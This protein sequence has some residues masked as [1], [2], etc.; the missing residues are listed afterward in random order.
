MTTIAGTDFVFD[1]NGKPATAAPIG[2]AFGVAAGSGGNV[3]VAS[4]THNLILQIS[5]GG[6][7]RTLAGNGV[8]GFSGEGALGVTAALNFPTG[9][10]VAPDGTLYIADFE[11][12]RVRRIRA[13]GTIET[14][15]GDINAVEIGDGG[16]AL[17]A[18]L[19]VPTALAFDTQGRLYIA[20]N[21]NHRIRRVDRDGTIRTIAGTGEAGYT[22][23]GGDAV[24]ARIGSPQGIAVD[25]EG[26]VYFTDEQTHTLRRV[27][28]AGRISTVAGNGAAG[29]GGD[30]GP[31]AGARLN[32]PR[33]VAIANTGT[34]YIAD[35]ANH[36]L[37]R[38]DSNGV[39]RTF[40]GT[41]VAAFGGDGGAAVN[42]SL[43]EVSG[44]AVGAAGV[45]Y[46]ADLANARVRRIAA[47]GTIATIAGNGL[48]RFSGDGGAAVA[49]VLDSPQGVGVASDGAILI[50]DSVNHRIRRIAPDG[51]IR[52]IAGTGAGGYSGDNGPAVDASLNL[53]QGTI[54]QDRN[55]VLY[56]CDRK[57]NRVRAIGRDGTIRTVAGNGRAGFGG[58]GGP[59]TQAMLDF[60]ADV[61]V[62]AAGN[63]YIADRFNHRIRRVTPDGVIQTVAGMGTAGFSGDG[64]VAREA[65]LRQPTGVTVDAQGNLIIC[66][67]GNAR[68]RRVGANNVIS[69]IAGNGAEEFNGDGEATAAAINGPYKAIFDQQGR[70]LIA[71]V[72]G[73][74]IRR[75]DSTGYLETIGG[76][77]EAKYSGDGAAPLEASLQLP[78]GLALGAGGEL[79]IADAGNNRIRA[80]LPAPPTWQI[81]R[82]SIVIESRGAGAPP[83][84]YLTAASTI[85]GVRFTVRAESDRNWLSV[86]AAAPF[87]TQSIAIAADP[88][89]LAAGVYRGRVI[90]DAP[91]AVPPQASVAVELRVGEPAG[92]ALDLAPKELAFLLSEGQE[93][94]QLA[95]LRNSG[96]D[97]VPYSVQLDD[98]AAARWLQIDGASGS[99]GPGAPESIVLRAGA[100]SLQQGE[101]RTTLR[102]TNQKTSETVLAP[103]RLVVANVQ[104]VL[105]LALTGLNFQA[106]EG[107]SA[108]DFPQKIGVLNA[109]KGSMNWTVTQAADAPPVRWLTLSDASGV[110]EAEGK[111]IPEFTVGVTAGGMT[112]GEYRARLRVDALGAANGTQFID[113]VLNVI[114]KTATPRPMVS[115][116]GLISV[117]AEGGAPPASVATG[118]LNLQQRK[119][120]FRSIRGT[121]DGG[122][123][124]LHRPSDGAL[125]FL[126][127]AGITLQPD[128][129]GL[130]A[131]VYEGVVT[132]MFQNQE[133]RNVK[134][135][136]LVTP[137]PVVGK[138]ARGIVADVCEASRVELV[139]TQL[140]GGFVVKPGQPVAIEVQAA[141][142]CGAPLRDGFALATFDDGS[143]A[144]PMTPLNDGRWTGT[145]TPQ[146]GER[147]VTVR[148]LAI[149][150]GS[151]RVQSE[152]SVSG[153]TGSDIQR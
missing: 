152:V 68:V 51:T 150:G 62:D 127:T 146:A 77:G 90:I 72:F 48:S 18:S 85:P 105:R 25:G 130:G 122:N 40:A 71:D 133:P 84:E 80:I 82:D 22:G 135:L 16:P 143:A 8:K 63:L 109:G 19:Y 5:P 39:I 151:K 110:S 55:G 65:Q 112:P 124:F 64:G 147:P 125:E 99:V 86:N 6:E 145:W 117:A 98:S 100:A 140:A 75:V 128:P 11:N 30:G 26:N 1:A 101:Y 12:H 88:R 89:G 58:D 139:F 28:P 137:R 43:N 131:G 120:E 45:V 37:R 83:P 3:F 27:T 74:R 102:V 59:A 13:D 7:I 121:F 66:D 14:V 138:S 91:A 29:F 31:A 17:F 21:G 97:A 42:A 2:Q 24:L 119:L 132:F 108:A 107:P 111:T 41:G 67:F 54:V 149:T 113:V 79:L 126:Q 93:S 129:A 78:V 144:V 94:R 10:A 104:A 44:V 61:E 52:T 36:R 96:A 142:N 92:A 60:P 23:D 57:N 34:I 134:L 141:D 69:T 95:V 15:A 53:P 106:M 73:A 81:S 115:R 87:M 153:R 32:G 136:M 4:P 70:L 38:I 50:A 49:A 123:W 20:D 47:D 148:V 103:V 33:G 35:T 114:P 116:T 46:I 56:F 118:I 9:V 76:N